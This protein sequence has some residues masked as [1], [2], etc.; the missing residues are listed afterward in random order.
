MK[1]AAGERLPD[2]VTEVAAPHPLEMSG[3]AAVQGGFAVVGDEE[4]RHGRIWPCG[5]RFAFPARLRGPESIAVGF[6]P[7]GEE[8]WLVLGEQNRRLID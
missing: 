7:S 3:V 5:E 6:G 1:N 4:N 8:I 2:G